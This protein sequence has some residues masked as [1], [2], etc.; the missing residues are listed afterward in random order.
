MPDNITRRRFLR[1]A[2]MGAAAAGAV[3][4]GGVGVFGALGGAASAAPALASSSDTPT[5]EGSSVIVHVVDAKKGRITVFDGTQEKDVTNF[6]LAQML[7]KAA[8]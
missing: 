7:M 8:K 3:A 4:A 5:M 2:S 6:D 1:H